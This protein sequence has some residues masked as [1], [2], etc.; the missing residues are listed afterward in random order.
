MASADNFKINLN[1]N[2]WGLVLGLGALGAA[3]YFRLGKVFWWLAVIISLGTTI[4]MA[5]SVCFYTI[6]YCK[7]KRKDWQSPG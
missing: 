1:Q 7:K 2:L 6:H 5:F 3:D 4:S